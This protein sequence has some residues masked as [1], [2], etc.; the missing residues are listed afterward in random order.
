MNIR[1]ITT[2]LAGIAITC[3]SCRKPA[4]DLSHEDETHTKEAECMVSFE[5]SGN[6]E[7]FNVAV[8]DEF[9]KNIWFVFR[10]NHYTN[11]SG[12]YYMDLWRIDWAY[13][14]KFDENTGEMTN[15]L[16]KIITNGENESVFKDYGENYNTS[17]QTHTDTYDF[18]GGFHGDERIDLDKDCGVTFFI[19]NDPVGEEMM[20][21]SFGWTKC[22]KFSYTQISTMHKTAL[23]KDGQPVESDHHI[24]ARHLKTTTFGKGGYKTEN[25]LEMKD[26]IDFY[27][28]FGICCIGRNV[29]E[30]GYNE[31]M[32]PVHFDASGVNRLEG[33]GKR[34]YCAW[35]DTNS[36]EVHVKSSLTHGGDD[37]VSKMHIW[38]NQ[39]YAKYYRRYPASGAHRTSEGEKFSSVM[40]VR[41]I[42]R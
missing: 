20:K 32:K 41:F 7:H 12:L 16:D 9:R 18:T 17:G 26:E 27:W 23:K 1:L 30:M 34:E 38:D 3:C 13:Q 24:V 35:S 21:K 37:K 6:T 31:D 39:N 5:K 10:I 14:G 25:T 8:K 22:D 40:E 2:I 15:I 11:H 19:G 33:I 4:T 36:I 28:Y 42:C 29:A